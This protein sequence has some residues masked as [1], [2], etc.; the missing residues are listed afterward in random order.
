LAEREA[1]RGAWAV[2]WLIDLD[3]FGATGGLEEE[4]A[5]EIEKRFSRQ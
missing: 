1:L 5:R 2:W 3:E 4:I